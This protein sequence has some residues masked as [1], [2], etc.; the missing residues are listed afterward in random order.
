[1][2]KKKVQEKAKELKRKLTKKSKECRV[3]LISKERK[4]K[5][6]E[7]KIRALEFN[8]SNSKRLSEQRLLLEQEQRSRKLNPTPTTEVFDGGSLSMFEI[9]SSSVLRSQIQRLQTNLHN[10]ETK[11]NFAL[12]TAKR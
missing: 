7:D 2:S 6:L 9:Q 4:I 5:E 11:L 1:V 8:H 3:K 12:K 10:S